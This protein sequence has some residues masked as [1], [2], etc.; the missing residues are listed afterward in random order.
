MS[1]VAC[2]TL[3]AAEFPLRSLLALGT[4]VQVRLESLIPVDHGPAPYAWVSGTTAAA[5]E[6]VGPDH[7]AVESVTPVDEVDGEVL[8]RVGWREPRDGVLSILAEASG[9]LLAAIGDAEGWSFR[10][11]FPNRDTLSTFYRTCRDAGVSATVDEVDGASRVADSVL[12]GPQREAILTA[13]DAGYFDVPRR[14]TLQDLAADLG[15]SDSAV[16]QRL[17]RG[18]TTL[19]TATLR[20]GT[21]REPLVGD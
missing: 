19:L 7:P 2:F 21:E 17:R 3:P 20:E 1:V 13:L 15:V 16:S 18:L 6:S 4:E 12:T 5:V 8:C 9:V 14:A 10:A 11:R